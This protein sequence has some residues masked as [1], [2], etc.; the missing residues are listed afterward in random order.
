MLLFYTKVFA[1]T[2]IRLA[3][4]I[5]IV[6][7]AL[8]GASAFLCTMLICHPFA[9]N[10]DLSIEGGS[11]GSQSAVFA[12]FGIMNLVTDVLVLAMPIKSL[13]G[14]RLEFWKKAS[15]LATFTVGFM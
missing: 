13:L 3:A 5:T 2:S 14:L 4:K 1:V 10:W 7:M 12:A 9:F 8:L 15:L 11:C 6:F